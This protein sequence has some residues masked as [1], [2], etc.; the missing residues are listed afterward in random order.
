MA[1]PSV[2][3]KRKRQAE[4][5]AW[6]TLARYL[7]IASAIAIALIVVE[8]DGYQYLIGNRY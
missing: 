4:I 7:L 5:E 8:S 3:R 6:Y 2:E 1:R